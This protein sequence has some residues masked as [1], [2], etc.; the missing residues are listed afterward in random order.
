MS[1][2]NVLFKTNRLC[3]LLLECLVIPPAVCGRLRDCYLQR[4]PDGYLEIHLL[5]RNGGGNR[6]DYERT[7]RLLRQH[8]R[9]VRDFDEPADSTYATYVFSIP[10]QFEV[11]LRTIVDSASSSAEEEILIPPPFAERFKRFMAKMD[12]PNDPEVQRVKKEMAPVMADIT[13][14]IDG[15]SPSES[16]PVEVEFVVIGKDPLT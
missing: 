1:L 16:S 9:F 2:Y 10:A 13:S 15:A 5:T 8:P 7:T 3:T 12:D 11:Q 6:P 4:H 14:Q